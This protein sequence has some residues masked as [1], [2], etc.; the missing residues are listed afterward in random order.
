MID[1]NAAKTNRAAVSSV[2]L[3]F[4]FLILPV[5]F[6]LLLFGFF[7]ID[8][9]VVLAVLIVNTFC[10]FNDHQWCYA[11]TE[12]YTSSVQSVQVFGHDLV[13]T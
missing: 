10:Y 1:L 4:Y 6:M 8:L 5:M 11:S 12:A 9:C 2:G 3:Y 13:S 7:I